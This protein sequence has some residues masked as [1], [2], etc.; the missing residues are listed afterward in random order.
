MP[1]LFDAPKFS[2]KVAG[3]R[4]T[5]GRHPKG[6]PEY[7]PIEKEITLDC[8]D[9]LGRRSASNDCRSQLNG[10]ALETAFGNFYDAVW[11]GH[12]QLG[13]ARSGQTEES[14]LPMEKSTVG[15]VSGSLVVGDEWFANV[16][17]AHRLL[18]AE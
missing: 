9:I 5:D 13:P 8:R 1:R 17:E 3:K 15:S 6:V 4:L 14:N 16:R 7:L 12:N 2:R 11:V 10:G 18:V